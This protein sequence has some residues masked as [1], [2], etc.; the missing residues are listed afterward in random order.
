MGT[1]RKQQTFIREW[2]ILLCRETSGHGPRPF[3][4]ILKE[5]RKYM[6]TH[7]GL[8]NLLQYVSGNVVYERAFYQ[9]R[10]CGTGTRRTHG[11]LKVG[12][13]VHVFAP[14]PPPTHTQ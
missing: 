10:L 3:T 14:P 11:W 13:V 2:A 9:R 12:L 6:H 4:P 8:K 7:V 5:V 1:V